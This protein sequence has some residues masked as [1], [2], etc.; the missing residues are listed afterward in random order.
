MAKKD[1]PKPK[2]PKIEGRQSTFLQ[3]VHRGGCCT[4]CYKSVLH[5]ERH[6]IQYRPEVTIDLCH[7]C[8]FKAHFLPF[9]L[10]NAKL[11]RLLCPVIKCKSSDNLLETY[12]K[13]FGIMSRSSHLK[14]ML[15]K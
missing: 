1:K 9:Q 14:A 11:Y 2:K 3:S 4:L 10:S 6:H 5:L 13:R 8:H 7:G 12:C 15:A